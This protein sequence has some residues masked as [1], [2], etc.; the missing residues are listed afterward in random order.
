[1]V[2]DKKATANMIG[3]A[4]GTMPYVNHLTVSN[5]SISRLNKYLLTFWV[6]RERDK[7]LKGEHLNK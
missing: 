6:I 7:P 4:T 1:M 5:E 2:Y 3:I